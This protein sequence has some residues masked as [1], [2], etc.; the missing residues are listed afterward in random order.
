[1]SSPIKIASVSLLTWLAFLSGAHATAICYG[2]SANFNG[3]R[4]TVANG[5]ISSSR[6]YLG[7]NIA[8]T[9]DTK[10]AIDRGDG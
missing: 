5:C 6:K 1:M 4:V 9:V 2:P 7:N 3:I 8:V 10:K